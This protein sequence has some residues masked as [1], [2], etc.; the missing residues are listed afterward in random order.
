MCGSNCD[1]EKELNKERLK[2]NASWQPG[3]QADSRSRN[4]TGQSREHALMKL[5]PLDTATPDLMGNGLEFF[6]FGK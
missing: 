3:R 2:A 1:S 4:L 6:F 5:A